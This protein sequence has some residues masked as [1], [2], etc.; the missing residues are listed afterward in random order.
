M[1]SSIGRPMCGIVEIFSN[2]EQSLRMLLQPEHSPH[3]P[4]TQPRLRETRRSTFQSLIGVVP[5]YQQPSRQPT[6]TAACWSLKNCRTGRHYL[7]FIGASVYNQW[8]GKDSYLYFQAAWSLRRRPAA[9]AQNLKTTVN[10]RL[11]GTLPFLLWKALR[12]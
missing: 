3:K 7:C 10:S 6:V 12:A 8:H 5:A 11:R 4:P 1:C 9:Y 2:T